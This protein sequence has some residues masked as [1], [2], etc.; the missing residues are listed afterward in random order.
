LQVFFHIYI[1]RLSDATEN[2]RKITNERDERAKAN[3]SPTRADV[4]EFNKR[5]QPLWDKM[6][7]AL[8]RIHNFVKNAPQRNAPPKKA[9]HEGNRLLILIRGHL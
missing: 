8:V 4:L 1:Y 5:Y 2:V 3:S 9:K 6:G 7:T